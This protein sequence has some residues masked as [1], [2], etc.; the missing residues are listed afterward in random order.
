MILIGTVNITR[1]RGAGD[2]HCPTC[3]QIR[4]Y[5][6]KSRRPFLTLYFIPTVPIGGAEFFVRCRGCRSHWDPAILHLDADAHREMREQ[7]FGGEAFRSAVLAAMEG[8]EMSHE[9]IETLIRIGERLLCEPIDREDVGRLCSSAKQNGITAENY[10]RSVS[11]NW[12]TEQQDFALQAMFVA[13]AAEG[14]LS[15]SAVRL[16]ASLRQILD[17]TDAEYQAAIEAATL[18]EVDTAAD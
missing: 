5:Q 18:W 16:L 13:A 7:Q 4:E 15:E 8:G 6:L 14:E 3:G 17:L 10:V 11:G 12:D 1:T 9:R 2:F